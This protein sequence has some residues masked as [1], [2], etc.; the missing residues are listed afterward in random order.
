ME[1]NNRTIKCSNMSMYEKMHLLTDMISASYDTVDSSIRSFPDAAV[2]TEMVMMASL[3]KKCNHGTH[4]KKPT[5]TFERADPYKT[6]GLAHGPVLDVLHDRGLLQN[7]APH[8][9]LVRDLA[10]LHLRPDGEHRD[11][12]KAQTV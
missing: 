2:V 4:A 9:P 11:I 1:P 5:K 7:P 8:L 3:S 10:H 6:P 12:A